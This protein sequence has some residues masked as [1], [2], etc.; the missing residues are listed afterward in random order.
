[1]NLIAQGNAKFNDVLEEII[2]EF[3]VKY[4]NFTEKISA[5]DG[6]F[7]Q[8]FHTLEDTLETAK[9]FSSI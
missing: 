9:P 6:L 5:M 7:H 1:M 4:I 2:K 8:S 3:R